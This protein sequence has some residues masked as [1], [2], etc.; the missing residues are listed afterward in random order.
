M[1]VPFLT[2]Q[3]VLMFLY[4]DFGSAQITTETLLLIQIHYGPA[5]NIASTI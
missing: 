5:L 1:V 4:P 3:L 2:H